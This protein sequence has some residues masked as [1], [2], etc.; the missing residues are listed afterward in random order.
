M[1]P[2]LSIPGL[3]ALALA[4][5]P[6]SVLTSAAEPITVAS[7]YFG[8]YHPG[9]PRNTRMKG[10]TWSEW[11]LVKAAKP[12]HEHDRKQHAGEFPDRP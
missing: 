5:P 9:D 4:L 11:E 10:A 8:N 1:K 3:A 12:R 7:Y 6:A 2:L